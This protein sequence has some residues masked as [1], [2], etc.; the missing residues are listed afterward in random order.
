MSDINVGMKSSH[1]KKIT[2]EIVWIEQVDGF[3]FGFHKDS[4]YIL[5]IKKPDK[6]R[7]DTAV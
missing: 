5:Q 6:N 3:I 1:L 7:L 4:K 2:S